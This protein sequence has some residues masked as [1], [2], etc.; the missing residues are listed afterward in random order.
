[1]KTF[2][3]K[4][5]NNDSMDDGFEV[6]QVADHLISKIEDINQASQKLD[7]TISKSFFPELLLG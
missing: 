4:I 7:R 6:P 5:S 1:M 3:A 2:L